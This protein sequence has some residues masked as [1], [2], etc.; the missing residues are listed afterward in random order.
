LQRV[1]AAPTVEKNLAFF[2]LD[3]G[4]QQGIKTIQEKM[5]TM[6]PQTRMQVTWKINSW[7]ADNVLSDWISAEDLK[8]ISLDA[9]RKEFLDDWGDDLGEEELLFYFLE[10]SGKLYV[11]DTEADELPVRH[12]LLISDLCKI[13]AGKMNPDSI[14][15]IW[16][17]KNPE[18]Y[19]AGYTLEFV[20]RNKL[21]RFPAEN[22]GDWYDVAIVMDALNL[23]L[24]TEK[25]PERFT[26]FELD[27]QVAYVV[28]ENPD[29][30]V[31]LASKY[32]IPLSNNP[33]EPMELGKEYEESLRKKI[34]ADG[35]TD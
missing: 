25:I 35:R 8:K 5:Q 2:I 13:T 21:Y 23:A 31:K 11:F 4:G 24:Q 22:L 27:S 28:F 16:H 34:E 18:D 14:K 17:Q 6:S 15:Q 29:R 3:H 32:S 19:E 1:N 10:K 30:I 26:M 7:K 9:A 20:F 12:D 33:E